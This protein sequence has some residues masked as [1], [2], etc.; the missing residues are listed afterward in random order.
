[1]LWCEWDPNRSSYWRWAEIAFQ[2]CQTAPPGLSS[3]CGVFSTLSWTTHPLT[4]SLLEPLEFPFVPSTQHLLT[5]RS[6]CPPDSPPGSSLYPHLWCPLLQEATSDA[7]SSRKPSLILRLGQAPTLGSPPQPHSLGH[8]WLGTG[9]SALL[10]FELVKIELEIS[11]V[12]SYT[13]R[14]RNQPRGRVWG[15]S[16]YYEGKNELK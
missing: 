12:L 4:S 7:L 13:I 10:D 14:S 9:L 6:L 3:H 2:W 5:F 1:M 11:A 16:C 8:H 15:N